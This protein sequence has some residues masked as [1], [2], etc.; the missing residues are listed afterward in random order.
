M[1]TLKREL[2]NSNATWRSDL[3]NITQKKGTSNNKTWKT[4]HRPEKFL[5]NNLLSLLEKLNH[6]M[7]LLPHYLKHKLTSKSSN[8]QIEIIKTLESWRK[9]ITQKKM[10]IKNNTN[11]KLYRTKESK[12]SRIIQNYQTYLEKHNHNSQGL[13]HHLKLRKK[14]Q[15]LS[16]P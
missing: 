10:K 5:K 15:K 9:N 2:E 12:S 14:S 3:I 7:T 13:I 1:I 4:N 8:T 6:K 11:M 16:H